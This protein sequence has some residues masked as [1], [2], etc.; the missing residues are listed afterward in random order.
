MGVEGVREKTKQLIL[1]GG[2]LAGKE[3]GDL[4]SELTDTGNKAGSGPLR[5]MSA[6]GRVGRAGRGSPHS[7][8]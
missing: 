6:K 7:G 2:I 5:L 3:E 1:E 4:P 8:R